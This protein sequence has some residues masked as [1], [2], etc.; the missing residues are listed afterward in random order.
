[1]KYYKHP[2]SAEVYRVSDDGKYDFWHAPHMDGESFH[3]DGKW[4]SSDQKIKY[5]IKQWGVYEITEQELKRFM[6]IHSL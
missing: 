1:M 5:A 4:I 3:Y 6:F 2:K